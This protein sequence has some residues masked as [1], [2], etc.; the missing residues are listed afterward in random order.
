MSARALARPVRWG[1]LGASNFAL[2]QMGP[3]IH[4]ARGGVLA[5]LATS[6]PAKATPFVDFAPGLRVHDSYDALLADP[7]IDAVYIPLPNHLHVDWTRKAA[8]AG[9]HVLCEK[10]I[11]LHASEIDDLIAL[12]DKTGLLIAEA[13]MIVHH[14]QWHKARAL[15]QEGALGRLI[16]VDGVFTYNNPDPGNVR[17]QPNMGGGGL[18]D[19]GVYVFGAARF[20]TGQEPEAILSADLDREHDF[21]TRAQITARFSDFSYAARVSMR[22]APWQEMT[23]HG[24]DGVMRLSAPFNPGVYGDAR[25]DLHLAEQITR[26]WRYTNRNQ[27]V[28]QA[29]AFNT[30][31]GTG[32]TYPC[33]LEFVRGTQAMIDMVLAAAL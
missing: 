13:Y 24:S 8:L 16:H 19:I 23:F 28:R 18:R 6:Q 11:A 21:D 14:P 1:I 17:N 30:S 4:A 22:M 31:V 26:S 32:D 2:K 27:Y 9:K 33:S 29:E 3:A 20:V 5:G 12:R 10:P 25:I 15:F 7:Q